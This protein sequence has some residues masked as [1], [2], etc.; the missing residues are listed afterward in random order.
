[1]KAAT[2]VRVS[3]EVQVEGFSL[4][5]Q[6]RVIAEFCQA[7]GLGHHPPVRRLGQVSLGRVRGEATRVQPDA[8]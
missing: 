3:S 8:D 4:D 7:R 6:R 5:A 1:M 2:Y